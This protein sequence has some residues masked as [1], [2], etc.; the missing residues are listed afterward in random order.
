VVVLAV[1]D[2]DLDFVRCRES[3]GRDEQEKGGDR[4]AH[5]QWV[6]IKAALFWQERRLPAA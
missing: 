6:T 5:K 1:H 2:E 3:D 4:G